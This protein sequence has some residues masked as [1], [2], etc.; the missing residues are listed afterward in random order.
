MKILHITTHLN[1]GGIV[2]YLS[3]V[4]I[5]LKRKGYDIIVASSGGHIQDVL[6]RNSIK[7]IHIPLNTKSEISP[8]VWFSYSIL[9]KY[10]IDN[11]VD[12][13]HAHTRVAQV[14]AALLS[15][16]FRIPV[17]TTCHGFFRPR[18]HRR[19][20][21]CWGN[22][23]IAISNQVKQHLIKD[24][25]VDERN[26]V[27]IHSG[28]DTQKYKTLGILEKENLKKEIGIKQN[29]LVVGSAG[30][31]S[32]VKGL[33]YFL[34]AIP[35]V[36]KEH[37]NV[38]FLLIGYGRDEERLRKISKDLKL[39]DK[40]IFYNPEKDIG[41]YLG[42]LD[43]FIAPS[44]QEGLGLSILEAQA[45]QIPVIAS[46]VGGIPDIIDDKV[47]GVLVEPRDSIALSS[48]IVRLLYDARLREYI[49]KNAY[50]RVVDQF[51][52]YKMIKQTEGV[53][54]CFSDR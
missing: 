38:T 35:H 10:L 48:A 7:H 51:S 28:I 21:P 50:Y 24:F 11:P 27:L 4:A 20:F 15:R 33:D 1:L 18:W 29:H 40:L 19:K 14:L 53:Y 44:I 54:R 8:K 31:F 25:G 26:V 30:R 22:K 46:N 23:V 32:T 5:E 34:K 43:V 49:Q 13:I 41:Y 12:L 45:Q 39:G 17:V 47:T 52:L 6:S 16:K 3:S 2:S 36:L 37:E 9:E 42:V